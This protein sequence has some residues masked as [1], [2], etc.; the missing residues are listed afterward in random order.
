MPLIIPSDVRKADLKFIHKH[1]L[2]FKATGTADSIAQAVARM[3]AVSEFTV[4][5]KQDPKFKVPSCNSEGLALAWKFLYFFLNTRDYVAAAMLLWGSKT[6]SPEPKAAQMMWNALFNF[7]LINV[8]GAA[9]CGKTFAPSA[10]C[11][12]DWILDPEWT[13]V[14]VVSNS[15]DHV[16]KNLFGDIIRLHGEASLDLPGKVD[17][18]SISLDKKRAF[19][20]F[21][22]TV[23]GGPVPKG[24]VKGMKIKTRPYHPIFGDNSRFRVILDEAQEIAA[25]VWDEIPNLLASVDNSTEHIKILAAANPKSE[26]SQYGQNCKPVG[27][28]DAIKDDQDEW[29]SETGWHVISINAM[30]TENVMQRKTIFPRMI[31]WEGVQKIIKSKAGGDAQHANCY[32]YIYGRFPKTSLMGAV[33]KAE[34]IRRSM[35]EWIF[36]GP[37]RSLGANDPAYTGDNPAFATGR[38]GRARGYYDFDDNQF[39]LPEPRIVVQVDAV[40]VL[41]RGDTQEMASEAM[42]RCRQLSVAP[43]GFGIDRTGI[44]QG[45]YDIMRRQWRTKVGISGLDHNDFAGICGIHYSEKATL[46]KICEEDSETARDTYD[47]IA[48]ELYFA[49]GKLMEFDC[50]GFGRTVDPKTFD[51]LGGRLGGMQVGLGRKITLESKE[52]FKA[53]TGGNSPDRGDVVTILLHVARTTTQGLIPK[54]KDTTPVVED[55][56]EGEWLGWGQSFAA[57][58]MEGMAGVGELSDTLRD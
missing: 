50:V 23:P 18:D 57:A 17:S 37:T 8:M 15:E 16:K 44:G 58:P 51:E 28:W 10:W 4:L 20:I 34:H 54:A 30:R 47:R 12:L 3:L 45:I 56:R 26:F 25:N 38:V 53:R 6:F 35:R 32:V 41:Q 11:L 40:A 7:S 31:T 46:T 2:D 33:C 21:V 39:D 13:R 9:S 49:A 19:G 22:M 52:V 36:D 1:L 29:E 24:K 42:E 5:M 14:T 27:G 55:Q 48:T 43:T